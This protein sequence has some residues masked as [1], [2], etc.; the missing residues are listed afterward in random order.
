MQRSF[1]KNVK[2]CENVL[3]FCKRTQ[4]IALF[5]Q[6]IYI[7]IYRY[8]QIQWVPK[9]YPAPKVYPPNEFFNF[10]GTQKNVWPFFW[11]HVVG[12]AQ[13]F[14]SVHF[15][16]ALTLNKFKNSRFSIKS[17]VQQESNQGVFNSDATELTA[18]PLVPF[19]ASQ[20]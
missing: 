18:R 4:N 9:V 5:L 8:K 19:K 6:Y 16:S 2:E 3:F 10:L 20:I 17:R 14:P 1:A 11:L 7:D 13:F 15:M 12:Q